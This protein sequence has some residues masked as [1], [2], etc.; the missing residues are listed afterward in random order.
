MSHRSDVAN[1]QTFLGDRRS[2]DDSIVFCDHAE[3]L[4][5]FQYEPSPDEAAVSPDLK[6]ILAA[7]D[8]RTTEGKGQ[9]AKSEIG[10]SPAA[11][12]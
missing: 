9:E 5:P 4:T 3:V 7:S 6:P 2:Q 10:R 8:D 12:S 11:G 1:L